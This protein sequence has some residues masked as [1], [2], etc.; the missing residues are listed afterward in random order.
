MLLPGLVCDAVL[1]RDQ[2][3]SLAPVAD[4]TVPDLTPFDSIEAMARA[5]LANAPERF[6]LAGLSMG[7][8]VALAMLHLAPERVE[9]LALLDTSAREDAPEQT[10]TRRVLMDMTR[11]GRFEEVLVL[12]LE[13][14]ID[15][16]RRSD[17]PLRDAIL[18]MERSAGPDA[19]LRQQNAII[20]RPNR[21]ATIA[22]SDC[23]L[24]VLC[25]DHDA[26]TPLEVHEEMRRARPDAAF[27]VIADCGHLSTLE[28][29]AE[30][31][32][33]LREWLGA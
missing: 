27:R 6:A 11:A 17:V 16:A 31:S 5:V 23:P 13:R 15:P 3:A 19:F 25:G 32:A 10:A 1:W 29:P 7:G 9:R 21:L 2:I 24:L 14:L 22:A 28:R 12:L 20:E 8:Y 33:A 26:I 4:I 18:A 30:V